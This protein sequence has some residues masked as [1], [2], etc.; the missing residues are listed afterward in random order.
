MTPKDIEH[1]DRWRQKTFSSPSLL[2]CCSAKEGC[3]YILTTAKILLQNHI[4]S[5]FKHFQTGQITCHAIICGKNHLALNTRVLLKRKLKS[6]SSFLLSPN[7]SKI[8]L[9]SFLTCPEK[10]WHVHPF[11]L[12]FIG[13]KIMML[14][15]TLFSQ[16]L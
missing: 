14:D 7:E 1:L 10:M 9:I 3:N 12:K 13:L 15:V 2:K 6:K 16:S 11:N 8:I 4:W 5:S